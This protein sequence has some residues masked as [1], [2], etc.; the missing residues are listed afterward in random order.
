MI[1][2]GLLRSG[3]LD[4]LLWVDHGIVLY[5]LVLNSFYALLL[6]LAIPELMEHWRISDDASLGLLRGADVIPPISV[7]VPAYNEQ[8]TIVPSVL[9]FLTLEY[10]SLEVVVVN[11]GSTDRTMELLIAAYELYET[12]GRL[13]AR[14][15]DRGG[16]RLLPVPGVLEADG[17]R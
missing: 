6:L 5:F 10:P 8:S 9:S 17:P 15:S 7:L 2:E 13:P 1:E 3:A 4:A 11:D 16:A 14:G 12:P